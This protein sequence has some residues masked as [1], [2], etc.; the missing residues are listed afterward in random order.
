MGFVTTLKM[1]GYKIVTLKIVRLV[2]SFK[3]CSPQSGV[4]DKIWSFSQNPECVYSVPI[5]P[6]SMN[7]L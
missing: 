2:L 1:R 5:L 3:L 7:M 4:R 6:A